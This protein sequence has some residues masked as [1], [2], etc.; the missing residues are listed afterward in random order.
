MSFLNTPVPY[1]IRGNFG[2]SGFSSVAEEFIRRKIN[3]IK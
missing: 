2:Y 1:D 3:P